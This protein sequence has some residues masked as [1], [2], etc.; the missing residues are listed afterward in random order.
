MEGSRC[1]QPASGCNM[2]GLAMPVLDYPRSQGASVTGGVVYRGCRMPGYAGSYF[3]G[4]FVSGFVRSFRLSGGAATD[5]RD[6]TAS[7]RGVRNPSSFGVDAD[8]EVYIVE[9]SGS[10]YRIEPVG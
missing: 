5:Q 8:G 6:W 4:D 7:F 10:V 1:F 2:A 9:Y 3:Y